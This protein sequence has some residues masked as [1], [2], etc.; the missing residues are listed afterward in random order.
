MEECRQLE[1]MFRLRQCYKPGSVRLVTKVVFVS[2]L[3]ASPR[4]EAVLI[5]NLY[6][7]RSHQIADK[8]AFDCVPT[9]S[10]GREAIMIVNH[11]GM[12]L[13]H[14]GDKSFSTVCSG[15]ARVEKRF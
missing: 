12:R 9:V 10:Q 7:M 11:C 1:V 8:V 4:R 5:L 2:V 15:R 6:A 3:G 13:N 14:V